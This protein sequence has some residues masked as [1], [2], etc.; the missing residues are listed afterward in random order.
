MLNYKF[1]K[2]LISIHI[3]KTGGTSFK[4]VL[5]T[6]FGKNLFFHYY[7][8]REG[9]MPVKYE[10]LPGICIH[11]HFNRKRN[12]GVQDYY[13]E[14]TQFITILRDRLCMQIYFKR[15]F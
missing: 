2:T 6:W 7:N 14:A 3:P 15:N 1:S 10:L 12:F 8:E 13:P 5:Y 9:I 4:D 11:G